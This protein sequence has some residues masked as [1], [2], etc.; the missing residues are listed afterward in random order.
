MLLFKIR[1]NMPQK[2]NHPKQMLVA[3]GKK[4]KSSQELLEVQANGIPN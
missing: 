4:L 3:S 2:S 1:G